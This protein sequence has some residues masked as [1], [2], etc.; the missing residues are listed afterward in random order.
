M[1][2]EPT[3]PFRTLSVLY[4]LGA[5]GFHAAYDRG[6]ARARR[7]PARVVSVGNLTTGG[8]GK[9]PA[10]RAL[11]EAASAL[12]LSP[13]VLTRGYGG[14]Q[15]GVLLDGRHGGEPARAEEFGDE[16]VLLSRWLP[17][18][19][20][21]VGKDRNGEAHRFAA[22]RGWPDLFLLDDGFQHRKLG[23]DHDVVIVDGSEATGR[24][25]PAGPLREPPSALRRAHRLLVTSDAASLG[26]LLD[27]WAPGIPRTRAWIEARGV[28]VMGEARSAGSLT[29]LRVHGV[30]GIARPERF[31]ELLV[32]EGAVLA[33][34]SA[35][36]DHHPFR[37]EEVRRVES[38]AAQAG[39]QPITT[40]KDEVRLLGLASQAWLVLDAALGVE[41]G[42]EA[43]LETVV[44]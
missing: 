40:A 18:V 20:V 36:P 29:G 25:L 33:G 10:V 39:A 24:L 5:R 13:A 7:L 21:I 23:R 26:S 22:G 28:R 27:R 2:T 43:V 37:P 35:F 17:G 41:G 38:E 19:P 32:R 42:W 11:A 44:R 4:G 9:T 14:R 1:R 30:A 8:T 6:L 3:L 15:S 31:R 34:W 12:G 16:A